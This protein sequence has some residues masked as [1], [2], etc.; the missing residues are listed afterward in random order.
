M[1]KEPYKSA[2]ANAIMEP[3]DQ[4]LFVRVHKLIIHEQEPDCV[5]KLALA[6]RDNVGRGSIAICSLIEVLKVV[7]KLFGKGN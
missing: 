7:T 2:T 3:A 4:A 1:G 6:V 5:N